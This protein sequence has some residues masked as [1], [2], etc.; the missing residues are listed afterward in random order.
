MRRKHDGISMSRILWRR[1]ASGV[2]ARDLGWI[3]ES[4]AT[5]W[6]TVRKASIVEE[7]AALTVG[8]KPRHLAYL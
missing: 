7:R 4:R 1:L 3:E 6:E 2:G 8:P 5:F